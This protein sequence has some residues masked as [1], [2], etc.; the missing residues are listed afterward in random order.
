[1]TPIFTL[2][3]SSAATTTLLLLIITASCMLRLTIKPDY[4]INMPYAQT[5]FPLVFI[6]WQHSDGV[7]EPYIL[8]RKAEERK[9]EDRKLYPGEFRWLE[10]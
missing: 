8:K 3:F 2:V 7:S 1:M 9:Q 5:Q 10:T 4:L 6:L